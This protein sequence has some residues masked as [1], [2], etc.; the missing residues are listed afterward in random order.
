MLLNTDRVGVFIDWDNIRTSLE[1]LSSMK[2][3]KIVMPWEEMTKYFKDFVMF[4]RFHLY[5]GE[6][7]NGVQELAH[8]LR[9]LGYNVL[10]K[11]TQ[12]IAQERGWQNRKNTDV[13]MTTDICFSES[14]FNHI[15]IF[16]GDGDFSY[17]IGELKSRG[18][19]VSVISYYNPTAGEINT[20]AR[21]LVQEADTFLQIE[22]F[23]AAIR[24]GELMGDV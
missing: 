5:G 17:L 4:A 9:G 20:T 6:G 13:E 3:E 14:L 18:K 16:S 7:G 22:E 1:V 24:N 10:L 12:L 2:N 11:R 21:A 8:R 15:I 19:R 23:I